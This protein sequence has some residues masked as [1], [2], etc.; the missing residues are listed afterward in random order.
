MTKLLLYLIQITCQNSLGTSTRAAD[1][2][3]DV[4]LSSADVIVGELKGPESTALTSNIHEPVPEDQALGELEQDWVD[5]VN[6]RNGHV[7]VS[8]SSGSSSSTKRKQQDRQEHQDTF[9]SS[10]LGD[11]ENLLFLQTGTCTKGEPSGH[12]QSSDDP[13][14]PERSWI[15]DENGRVMCKF[16]SGKEH[17][18]GI[19]S[20][21]I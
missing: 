17:A 16:K 15:N 6:S 8:C 20:I 2:A 18:L 5:A 19:S 11:A 10:N 14:V 12:R 13:D 7:S 4:I 21:C 1:D 9:G 3:T